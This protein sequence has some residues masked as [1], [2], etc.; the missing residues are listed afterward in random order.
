MDGK[1]NVGRVKVGI[2]FIAT[3]AG[4]STK[5]CGFARGG[6]GSRDGAGTS[7]HSGRVVTGG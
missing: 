6:S 2:F 5:G 7:F 4:T 3:G 1:F